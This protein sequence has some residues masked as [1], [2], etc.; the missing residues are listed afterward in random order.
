MKRLDAARIIDIIDHRIGRNT[1]NF[2]M[3]ETTWGVVAARDTINRTVDVFLYGSATASEDFRIIGGA[4][5]AVATVV[6]VAIDKKSDDRW[7]MEP[8]LC[9]EP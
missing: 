5:P 4:V 9:A 8:I 6:K 3:V 7:V 2:A 1:R